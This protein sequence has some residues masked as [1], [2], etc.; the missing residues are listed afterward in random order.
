MVAQLR[1]AGISVEV[2]PQHPNGRFARLNDPETNQLW[3]P[4]GIAPH[5]QGGLQSRTLRPRWKI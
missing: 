4:E 1:A 2:D 5:K 3:E